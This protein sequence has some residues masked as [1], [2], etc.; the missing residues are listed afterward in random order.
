M[1]GVLPIWV[2]EQG[3]STHEKLNTAFEEAVREGIACPSRAVVWWLQS[4]SL[5]GPPLSRNAF[6]PPWWILELYRKLKEVCKHVAGRDF[7]Q[8]LRFIS[9]MFTVFWFLNQKPSMK[10]HHKEV[11]DNTAVS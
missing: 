5:R 11:T 10:C 7:S 4:L 2:T 8:V 6:K 9:L 1:Q 3:W